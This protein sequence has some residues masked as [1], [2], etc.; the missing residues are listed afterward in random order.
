M[1]FDEFISRAQD[2]ITV[3]KVFGEP[4]EKDGLTVIPAARVMGGSGG[5]IGQ[6]DSGQQGE[7]GGFGIMAR[8]AGAFVIRDG[9]ITWR[10]AVDPS[11]VIAAAAAVAIVAIVAGAISRMARWQPS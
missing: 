6:D 11:T 2:A 3:R 7:G 1:Q 9:E 4:F 5:G 10:P 8:P